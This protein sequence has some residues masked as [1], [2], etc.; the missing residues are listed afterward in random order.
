MGYR[1][2]QTLSAQNVLTRGNPQPTAKPPWL[3]GVGKKKP[4][5]HKKDLRNAQ[6]HPWRRQEHGKACTGKRGQRWV[7]QQAH[8][9]ERR[10]GWEMKVLGC[11]SQ[12]LHQKADTARFAPSPRSKI[13]VTC[14]RTPLFFFFY[15]L[16][17]NFNVGDHNGGF[18]PFF[19][20]AS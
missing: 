5:A 7:L 13:S 17:F 1:R 18:V 10:A 15:L 6:K 8:T 3:V 19:R 9:P 20:R 2:N 16:L 14:S 11:R 12:A 4:Q